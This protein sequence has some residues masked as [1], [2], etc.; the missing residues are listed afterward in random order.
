MHRKQAGLTQEMLS[1]KA[2]LTSKYLGE[3]ERGTVNVSIDSLVR[4][5][6]AVGVCVQEL[7]RDF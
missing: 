5:A 4:I 7:T 6:R 3:V 2:D 1:E